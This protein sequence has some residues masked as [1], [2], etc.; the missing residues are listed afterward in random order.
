MLYPSHIITWTLST[1]DNKLGDEFHLST[2]VIFPENMLLGII[3]TWSQ[4]SYIMI[5]RCIAFVNIIVTHVSLMNVI[6]D[7]ALQGPSLR[8]ICGKFS[9]DCIFKS[10]EVCSTRDDGKEAWPVL[11][12]G[13]K[14]WNKDKPNR[15][16]F[17]LDEDTFN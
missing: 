15:R 16:I 2:L 9:F 11:K 13:M 17:Y 5:L 12:W 14:S 8:R 10:A 7:L 1:Q 4:I 3:P 6:S